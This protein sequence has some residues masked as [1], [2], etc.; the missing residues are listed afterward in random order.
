MVDL[1]FS[2]GAEVSE[3]LSLKLPPNVV[4]ESARASFSVLGE[5]PKCPILVPYST[6]CILTVCTVFLFPT[7]L[8]ITA[9]TLTS[10][11]SPFLGLLIAS[12]HTSVPGRLIF[13][14]NLHLFTSANNSFLL[15][16]SDSL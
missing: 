10:F 16:D 11:S 5:C 6:T 14:K 3:Q 7:F 15:N 1:V 8:R 12:N 2:L 4:E 13:P 9:V